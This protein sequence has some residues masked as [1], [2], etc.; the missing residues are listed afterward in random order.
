MVRSDTSGFVRCR[1]DPHRRQVKARHC[2]E[3]LP[4]QSKS[5]VADFDHFIEWPNP[6]YS[7]VR[8]GR[9]RGWGSG[10]VALRCS[11]ARPPTPSLPHKGG[12]SPCSSRSLT[13]LPRA[14][15]LPLR[16]L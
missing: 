9:G 8:L 3:L 5:A 10:D 13:W 16:R 4:S 2:D 7:E 6:H 11:T 12:G 1:G 15:S 14:L